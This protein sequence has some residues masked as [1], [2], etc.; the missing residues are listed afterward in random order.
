MDLPKTADGATICYGDIVHYLFYYHDGAARYREPQIRTLTI[1]TENLSLRDGI[2]LI[3]RPETHSAL[4]PKDVY[5]DR[6]RLVTICR[7]YWRDRIKEL[8]AKKK[9]WD[10]DVKIKRLCRVIQTNSA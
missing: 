4:F 8:R 9:V 6:R 7:N 10:D 3:K 1:S 2:W 5:R